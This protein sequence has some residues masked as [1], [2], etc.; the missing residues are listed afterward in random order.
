MYNGA[1]ESDT[2]PLT[3]GK[4]RGQS[5]HAVDQ[6]RRQNPRGPLHPVA[7]V[8][9]TPRFQSHRDILFQSQKFQPPMILKDQTC[10]STKCGAFA[11]A[12]LL[13]PAHDATS[14]P[15]RSRPTD[16]DQ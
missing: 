16:E 11:G 2:L 15:D 13:P 1:C 14:L 12:I 8:A 6:T 4:P 9:G 10:S 7:T 3:T 5:I